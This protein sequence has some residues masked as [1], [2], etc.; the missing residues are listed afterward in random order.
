L[1]VSTIILW[2]VVLF[3]A[4]LL[5]G[6]LR[7]LGPL[8]WRLDQLQ[9]VMPSRLGRDGLKLGK[10]APD[11]TLPVVAGGEMALYEFACR[12]VLLVFV[13][14]GCSLC[15]QVVLSLEKIA[16]VSHRFLGNLTILLLR[17]AYPGIG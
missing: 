15:H 14:G 5:L 3:L 16:R 9:A 2:A 10:K 13:Q 12:K 7:T 11:F 17:T 1:L 4:F 8:S 6:A